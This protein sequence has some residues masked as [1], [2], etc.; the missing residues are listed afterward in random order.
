MKAA[1]YRRPGLLSV[2]R[3]P[4][5]VP[6]DGEVLVRVARCGVCHTDVKK[7]Q[8][9]LQPAPRIYGHEISGTIAEIGP[10]VGAW[11]VGDR[12][13]LL[14][15]VPCGQCHYC[16]HGSS[17]QCDSY[18]RTGTTAGFEAAGG[19][20]SQFVLARDWIV[21]GGMVRLPVHV[22]MDEAALLEPL[23]TCAKAVSR[24]GTPAGSV[25]A[26]V[27]QGPIGLMLT[28]LLKAC[29]C[30]VLAIE[31][32]A[33]R[34]GISLAFGADAAFAPDDPDAADG[35]S[36]ATDG[37]GADAAVVATADHEAIALAMRLVR[38]G[39]RVL[40]FGSTQRADPVRLDAGDVCV[41][42]IDVIGSY[43][44]DIGR[45]GETA[46][47]LFGRASEWRRL[48]THV[49]PLADVNS[50]IDLAAHRRDGSLKVLI[51]P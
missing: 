34:R 5:P 20:F 14:H 26:V 4:V 12:V 39:G 48:V 8:H 41:R 28:A 38:S 29:G 49:L 40:L 16:R 37:R 32:D 22:G 44:S 17:A 27:G 18:R 19:G 42:E 24:L 2:E 7:I 23:T 9:D 10:G 1:V 30:V 43:G 50:A 11:S 45:L 31:P 51:A 35:A 47:L 25:V 6:A 36:R 15:H 46:E 21:R 13:A 33:V 3:V